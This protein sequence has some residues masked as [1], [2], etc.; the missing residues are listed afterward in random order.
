MTEIVVPGS[1]DRRAVEE[2]AIRARPG[3][4]R[5]EIA[6]E[7]ARLTDRIDDVANLHCC[8]PMLRLRAI[9]RRPS[10][11]DHSWWR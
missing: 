10:R 6:M 4:D 9:M 1:Q 8:C 2:E 3:L 5:H 7:I 11:T